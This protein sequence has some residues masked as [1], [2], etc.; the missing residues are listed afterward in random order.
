[1]LRSL[2]TRLLLLWIF[3]AVTGASLAVIMLGMYR[4]GAG[5]QIEAGE[6][7]ASDACAAIQSEFASYRSARAAVDA[8]P[9][10]LL[11]VLVERAL[12]DRAGVE[13]GI[14]SRSRGFVA[15]AFPTYEGGSV[16]H[17]VPEAEQARISSLADQSAQAGLPQLELQRGKREA[18][19]V[20]AC[21][22]A[23]NADVAAWTLRRVPAELARVYDRL[24]IGLG[25]L[26]VF[27][28]GSGIWL[29]AMLHRWSRR[30]TAIEQALGEQNLDHL[31]QLAAT[32]EQELDRIVA[33]LNGFSTRLRAALDESDKLSHEL[34][35]ADR[36]AALG[37]M[38][39]GLAHE[40]RNPI[41]AMRLKAENAL[42]QPGPRQQAALQAILGQVERLDKLLAAMLAMTQPLTLH[43]Q[44]ADIAPW[45][46]E[47][48]QAMHEAA[49]RAGVTLTVSTSVTEWT[50]DPLHL[51]R[52]LDN[53][54][55]NS[56]RHS[57]NGGSIAITASVSMQTL[58]LSVRDEGSGVSPEMKDHLF[59]P[60]A[61][62]RPD[63]AGLGLALVREIA[64]AHG[65]DVH[66]VEVERGACFEL[67][68]P[69]RAS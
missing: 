55:W 13:G 54:L 35:R 2:R 67:R 60:F 5:F 53:L 59:E 39:A 44:R 31:P 21:P 19:I 50:F 37:R 41:A 66:H 9:A 42:A 34:A 30:A 51:A 8:P 23:G 1:M 25:V 49:Q 46:E 20:A 48:A 64:I 33:A 10:D 26:L 47:R 38:A 58:I 36:L 56:L 69:W 43:L 7:G 28:L 15:Y 16:K 68:L 29:I 63:G 6:R 32:G 22:L 4:Q 17:D 45:L 40:I 61:S 57:A 18:S 14:W 62:S 65:G 11:Y 24:A 27:V 12:H 52:A 3:I